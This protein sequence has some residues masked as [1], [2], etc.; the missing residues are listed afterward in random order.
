[1]D[2]CQVLVRIL[3]TPIAKYWLVSRAGSKFTKEEL[4][5]FRIELN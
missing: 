1:M 4:L 3:I 2:A 5:V